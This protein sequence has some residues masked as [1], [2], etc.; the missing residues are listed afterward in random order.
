MSPK[1]KS[2][3]NGIIAIFLVLAFLLVTNLLQET[4]IFQ[5]SKLDSRDL[6]YWEYD[7]GFIKGS[8]EFS[9]E[10]NKETCWLLVHSYTSTPKEM[11]ELAEKINSDSGDYVRV[12]LLEG[13]GQ[14][15]SKLLDESLDTWYPQIENELI[16][17]QKECQKINVLGSSLT[18]PLVLKL[19][20]EYDLNNIFVL[21]SF[22]YLPYKPY[23]ILPLRTYIN[24]FTPL[25]HYNKK[26]EIAQINSQKGKEN[27]IAY[28]NMPYLPIKNSFEFIDHSVLNLN[29]IQEPIFIVHSENDPTASKKSAEAIYQ[30]ISSKTKSLKWYNN[31]SHVLLMDNDKNQLIQDI[32]DF[33]NNEK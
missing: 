3:I 22:I 11:K 30:K 10:G 7:S 21:N 8:Q 6:E 13:H 28:W 24:I 4:G 2:F 25:I 19:A 5:K 20:S 16:N 15:P 32:I 1:K 33:N 14:V 29:K 27:H 9:L 23:R 31:S 12:P 17:L 18:S 26:M